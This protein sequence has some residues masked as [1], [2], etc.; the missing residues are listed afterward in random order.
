MVCA[1][2]FDNVNTDISMLA[3][4]RIH[5]PVTEALFSSFESFFELITPHTLNN[6][7]VGSV[8]G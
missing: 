4:S 3:V 5:A 8:S 1:R 7:S 2:S 6:K